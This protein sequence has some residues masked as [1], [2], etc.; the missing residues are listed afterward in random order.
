MSF[1]DGLL[2]I[3]VLLEIFL[4]G[5]VILWFVYLVLG[6]I[7]NR[8]L[9]LIIL[10]LAMAISFFRIAG[11]DASMLLA[12]TLVYGL[13]IA[14]LVPPFVFPDR[15]REP[16]TFRRI[17]ICDFLV[18]AVGAFL[19]F[20]LVMSGLSMVPFIFW[21]TPYSNGVIYICAMLFDMGFAALIYHVMKE[22]DEI[23]GVKQGEKL[24]D[25]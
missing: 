18:S 8:T 12:G 17:V 11:A 5:V 3:V 15:T 7:E 16:I 1:T 4:I 6:K 2:G 13:P 24:R 22:Q 19:P 23:R 20:F 14:I 10:V 9:R 25:Q 21:H